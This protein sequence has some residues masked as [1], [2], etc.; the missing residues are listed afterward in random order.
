MTTQTWD[1]TELGREFPQCQTLQAIIT[2]LE[3]VFNKKGEVICEIRV[4]GMLI[5]EDDEKKFAESSA[6]EIENIEVRTNRP[7]DLIRNAMASVLA[8][9]PG[10]DRASLGAAEKLRSSNFQ[11]AQKSFGEVMEGCQWVCDTLLHVRGAASSTGRPLAHPERWHEAEKLI[12]Q[13]V[14]EVSGAY[15]NNDL[16]LVADLLEY[17]VTGAAAVWKEVIE[18]ESR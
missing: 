16:V 10:L 6:N 18:N 9:L 3:G 11:E 17:E 4:N 1:K 12:G 13:V 8:F 7:D 5:D 14:K 2:S 15:G